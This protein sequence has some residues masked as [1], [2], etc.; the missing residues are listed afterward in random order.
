MALLLCD[1][2][3]PT[4]SLP[5]ALSQGW[6][7]AERQASAARPRMIP[8]DLWGPGPGSWWPCGRFAGR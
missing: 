5:Q 8:R 4:S 3:S 2:V 6:E 7:V 1:S